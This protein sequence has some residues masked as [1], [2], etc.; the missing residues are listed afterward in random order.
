MSDKLQRAVSLSIASGYQLDKHAFDLLSTLSQTEDPVELIRE[1]IRR[2]KDF[3]EKTLFIRR[4]H[5][6][7]I[8]KEPTPER[9]EEELIEPKS[10]LPI[11]G[12]K[13]GVYPYAKD[14]EADIEV[15]QD[16]TDEIC[17]TG[18]VEEYL[19]YF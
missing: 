16:P 3:P 17:E 8:I 6:E 9:K 14:V 2:L 19:E 13:R 5:L 15:I 11:L 1:A 12:A 18:S 7:E 10:S 4:N